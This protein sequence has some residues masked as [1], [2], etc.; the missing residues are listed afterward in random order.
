MDAVEVVVDLGGVIPALRRVGRYVDEPDDAWDEIADEAARAVASHTPVVS[1]RLRSR[2]RGRA[3]RRK[4]TVTVSTDYAGA[5]NYGWAARNIE[6]AE[7]VQ[8]AD[9]DMQPRAVQLLE[10][11]INHKITEQRFR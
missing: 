11:G 9:A 1:G 8:K 6:P 3:G 7:F 4:A 2:V 5:I 10:D